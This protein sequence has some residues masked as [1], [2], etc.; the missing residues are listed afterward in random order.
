MKSTVRRGLLVV[1]AAFSVVLVISAQERVKPIVVPLPGVIRPLGLPVG[2]RPGPVDPL[3][4]LVNFIGVIPIDETAAGLKPRPGSVPFASGDIAWVDQTRGRLYLTDRS[5]FTIDIFDAVNDLFV[6]RVPGFLGPVPGPTGALAAGPYG[7]L[8]TENNI[9]WAGDGASITQ[10][11]DLNLDPPAIIKSISVG[12]GP[13]DGRAD[14]LGYDPLEHIVMMGSGQAKPPFVTLISTDSYQVLGKIQFPD[15]SGIE[16]PVWDAQLHRFL[17][18]IPASPSSYVAVVDPVNISVTKKYFLNPAGCG[19]TGL[20]LAPF[21]RMLVSCGFP[22]IMNAIDGHVITTI[23]QVHGGDEIWYNNGDGRLY[24]TSTDLNGVTVLGVIDVES[25]TWLQNIPVARGRNPAA[26][27]Q[28]NHIFVPVTNPP[29][30]TPDTTVCAT[31]GLKGC[32]AVFGHAT[33]AN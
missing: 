18:T 30:G 23:T 33:S 10:V 29:A 7:V 17:V 16:Q 9:L 11:V 22:I 12:N 24:V 21:Q 3:Q 26:Y 6:G 5:N 14:E 20:F 32:I 4:G 2:D 13:A 31:F 1:G 25:G 27:E 8:V 15:A 28:N 19:A